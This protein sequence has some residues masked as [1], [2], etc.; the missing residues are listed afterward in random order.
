MMYM[1]YCK[2][3]HRVYMLNG[4][5]QQCPKCHKVFLELKISYSYNT[6]KRVCFVRLYCQFTMKYYKNPCFLFFLI[7]SYIFRLHN[8]KERCQ[9]RRQIQQMVQRTA[10][11]SASDHASHLSVK[12]QDRQA[13]TCQI[14][15]FF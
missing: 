5:K 3:C 4:H 12:R 15:C 10:G 8:E 9:N 6:L 7:K 13:F 14:F 1:H 11:S 2:S